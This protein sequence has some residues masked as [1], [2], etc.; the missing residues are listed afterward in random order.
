MTTIQFELPC[1]AVT[2]RQRI[3]GDNASSEGAGDDRMLA[4]KLGGEVVAHDHRHDE[5]ARLLARDPFLA[6]P[7]GAD[8]I[9]RSVVK[10]RPHNK[11]GLGR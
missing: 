6:F 7:S 10:R 1:G 8:T 5:D 11:R 9:E 2:A 4:V 3:E